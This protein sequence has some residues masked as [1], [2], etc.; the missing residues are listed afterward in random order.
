MDNQ[1]S[2]NHPES[3]QLPPL[4]QLQPN[5]PGPWA[6]LTLVMGIIAVLNCCTV[7]GAIFFGFLALIFAWVEFSKEANN[8]EPQAGRTLTI[9]G[10]IFGILAMIIGALEI[11][12]I[13]MFLQPIQDWWKDNWD[14]M[15]KKFV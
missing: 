5:N 11:V 8:Q 15:S 3:N 6:V 12:G 7:I 2:F 4:T 13:I 10:L 14:T 1:Q 9:I